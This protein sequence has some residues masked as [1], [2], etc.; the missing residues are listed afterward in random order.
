ML[1]DLDGHIN[2][3]GTNGA[4]KTTCLRLIPLF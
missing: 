1:L 2:S 3:S 4:G